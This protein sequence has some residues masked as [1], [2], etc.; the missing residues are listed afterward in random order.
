MLLLD[1]PA[2][3]LDIAAL[4]FL[5]DSLA[6][7]PGALV[8]VSHDRALM[9]RLCTEVIALDGQGGA[10]SHA[11]LDQWLVAYERTK[12]SKTERPSKP[13]KARS[14]SSAKPRKLSYR[15]QQELDGMEAAI[16]AAEEHVVQC[17]AGVDQAA[18]AASHV[19][20]ADACHTLEE[21]HQDL[22]RLYQRWQELEAKGTAAP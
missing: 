10:A 19:A 2:N 1:E 22:E 12:P 17:Q 7:F 13:E 14:A 16:L 4:E 3:D 8:L 18:A 15:E 9:D 5:E 21:A 6:E 11:S 20:L